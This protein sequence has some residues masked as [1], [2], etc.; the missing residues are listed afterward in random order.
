MEAIYFVKSSI[1]NVDCICADFTRVPHRYSCSH[2]FFLPP[3]TQKVVHKLQNGV[4]GKFVKR[5]E[6]IF[7][8]FRPVESQMFTLNDPMSLEKLFSSECHNIVSST[9]NKI[10]LQLVSVCAT[11]GEY[12]IVR[13]YKPDHPN[14]EAHM[15][16]FM[17]AQEFQHRL[18]DYARSHSNFPD[19]TEKRPRSI[20]I[21]TDRTIDLNSPFLHEFTYQAMVYDLLEF[22]NWNKI[23]YVPENNKNAPSEK[24]EG[25][26][27]EKD[28]EWVSLRHSHMEETNITLTEK[29]NKLKKDHPQ[30]FTDSNTKTSAGDIKN[31]GLALP[32]FIEMRDRYSLHIN[33]ASECKDIIEKHNLLDL[34]VLEQTMATGLN[35]D[36]SKP[37]SITD[38]F[39]SLLADERV[40][41]ADRLRL[42]L[43]YSLF[44]RGLIPSD[45]IR[46]QQHCNL[47]NDDLK[48]IYNF[49]KLGAPTTKD[50]PAMKISKSDLP[51]RFSS[52]VTGDFYETSRYVNG[53]HNVIDMLL[54]GKLSPEYFPYTKDQPTDEDEAAAAAGV[55]SLRN[56]R[57]R[58][59][60]A[61]TSSTTQSARQRIFVF[62][63]GGITASET[64]SC[65]ELSKTHTRE[66][67]VGS[68][69]FTTPRKFL[70]S[71]LNL[72]KPR[73]ELHLQE[74]IPESDRAPS[75]LY[76]SDR[77]TKIATSSTSVP[78][79]PPTPAVSE[80]QGQSM[81]VITQSVKTDTHSKTSKNEKEKKKGKLGKFFK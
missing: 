46:L 34:S 33:L 18:D 67:I 58:A 57:Q 72:S 51:H 15:L 41:E 52:I 64:R 20:F 26:V 7:L 36:G 73:H 28:P 56:P 35:S 23:D 68:N 1:Y 31:M 24:I 16:S 65:Y 49:A 77:E 60:W 47:K 19:T 80:N 76:E 4:A 8:D 11:L 10:A 13:F 9:I 2:V 70:K 71:L 55:N 50:S 66:I 43:L 3:M 29:F 17:I 45:F 37:K 14:Y 27:T 32:G 69:D 39:V 22:K 25:K 79:N 81:S 63:A 30:F 54:S 6:E 62:V 42:I 40:L 12:P 61:L 48:A 5:C 53:L 59:N 38:D 78:S 21:I 44:R 74:D 75:F